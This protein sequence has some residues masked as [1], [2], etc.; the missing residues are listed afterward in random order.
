M[1]AAIADFSAI[2]GADTGVATQFLQMTDGDA[3]QA[4]QLFFDSPELGSAMANQT[5]SAPPQ[6]PSAPQRNV[7]RGRTDS[8][9]VVHLDSDDDVVMEDDDDTS[10]NRASGGDAARTTSEARATTSTPPA[11]S[12]AFGDYEDD[13]AIARRMQ[14][15]LY[16]GGDMAGDYN[17]GVRA[18]LARTTETLVGPGADWTADDM[19]EAVLEQMR[20]RAQPRPS[21][22]LKNHVLQVPTNT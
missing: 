4:I 11:P 8:D 15:E 20:A 6:Q 1:D 17:S 14:E 10:I 19:H 12:A 9:G 18:P 3:Q 2:T 22:L 5:P 13:E 16:A 7:N 21:T